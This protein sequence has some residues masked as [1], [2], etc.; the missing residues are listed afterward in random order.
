MGE[1]PQK[2]FKQWFSAKGALTP[3]AWILEICKSVYDWW[4]LWA[5]AAL[6][7]H[8]TVLL[9][10]VWD[11]P[12]EW[13]LVPCLTWLL[14]APVDNHASKNL[15]ISSEPEFILI[16]ILTQSTFSTA[17]LIVNFPGLQQ[18]DKLWESCN[19]FVWN[20]PRVGGHFGKSTLD[21]ATWLWSLNTTQHTG[22]S[23][24]LE[25]VCL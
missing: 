21:I 4:Q 13:S 6:N 24:H 11:W 23:V 14:N 20:L 3:R 16:Y 12:T 7:G 25:W 9:D 15:F 2:S 8:R 18:L 19:F 10:N 5:Q 17:L 22:T 1:A